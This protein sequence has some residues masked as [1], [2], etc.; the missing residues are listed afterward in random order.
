MG[1][2][3]LVGRNP[4]NHRS[5]RLHHRTSCIM[6]QKCLGGTNPP[7]ALARSISA[8]FTR[9]TRA[10]S[11]SAAAAANWLR[12]R[13]GRNQQGDGHVFR[14]L[15]KIR[16]LSPDATIHGERR[17][18]WRAPFHGASADPR[19]GGHCGHWLRVVFQSACS[20]EV[21][22]SRQ[23]P[24]TSAIVRSVTRRI[25]VAKLWRYSAINRSTLLR[26]RSNAESILSSRS[27]SE[28][29][30]RNA[31]ASSARSSNPTPL[32]TSVNF[33]FVFAS[34]KYAFAISIASASVSVLLRKSGS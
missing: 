33:F 17:C 13:F 31:S 27:R 25:C 5:I 14:P 34:W 18:G 8:T 28:I 20:S 16:S 22:G 1:C 32:R 19:S 26:R 2:G 29:A 9:R 7:S 15:P 30:T 4:L 10:T 3:G 11:R 6:E 21:E 24:P 23:G 12:L